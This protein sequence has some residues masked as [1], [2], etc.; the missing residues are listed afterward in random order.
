MRGIGG[1]RR[2]GAALLSTAVVFGV[3][4]AW[5]PRATAQQDPS[6]TKTAAETKT[7]ATKGRVV[8]SVPAVAASSQP[9]QSVLIP[10]AYQRERKHLAGTTPPKPDDLRRL[11]VEQRRV[12][13]IHLASHPRVDAARHMVKAA[14]NGPNPTMSTF[15]WSQRG[16]VGSVKDQQL[17]GDCWDFA[18]VGVFESMYAIRNGGRANLLRLSEEQLL[19]CN[20][21]TNPTCTCCGGW[22]AFDYIRDNGLVGASKLAYTSGTVA[23][24]ANS[25]GCPQVVGRVYK[26]AAW[27]YVDGADKVPAPDVI[28]GALCDHGPLISAVA[29]TDAFQNY[30]PQ[31]YPGGV[32]KEDN[33]PIGSINHAV[34]IVGWT[35]Q[36]WIVRNS[37]GTDWGANGY[38]LIAYGSNNIGYGAA[39][40]EVDPQ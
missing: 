5:Q 36:G 25:P 11:M 3:T 26:A 2:I 39:W 18:A 23:C 10:P 40:V 4:F 24:P 1:W 31:D 22:W 28:K 33:V 9:G 8:E 37:W 16:V 7:A 34:M 12:S 15:D 19:R 17:C 6:T 35:P 14:G 38:I 32:F 20:N 29:V 13:S 30:R 21:L 27:D